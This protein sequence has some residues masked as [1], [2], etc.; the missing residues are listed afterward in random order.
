M[1]DVAIVN[2]GSGRLDVESIKAV[3]SLAKEEDT[4]GLKTKKPCDKWLQ[5]GTSLGVAT[6]GANRQPD[7]RRNDCKHGV[8]ES[9]DGLSHEIPEAWSTVLNILKGEVFEIVS[10]RKRDQEKNVL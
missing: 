3:A 6:E 1:E 10:V 2:L 4:D 5:V 7:M 9:D 8:V